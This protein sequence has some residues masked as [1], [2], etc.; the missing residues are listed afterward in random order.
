MNERDLATA[1]L[2]PAH[3]IHISRFDWAALRIMATTKDEGSTL[4]GI[5]VKSNPLIP[6]GFVL[7]ADRYGNL[8]HI[9]DLRSDH[10]SVEG[11]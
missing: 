6:E 3:T 8:L 5:A 7:V 1:L 11:K 2:P 9:I 4:D 10:A